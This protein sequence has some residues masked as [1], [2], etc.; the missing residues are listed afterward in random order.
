M[1]V[2][3]SAS[4]LEQDPDLK[5]QMGKAQFACFCGKSEQTFRALV[6]LTNPVFTYRDMP[7]GSER[8]DP[9]PGFTDA[10]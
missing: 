1:G 6:L 2:Y 9:I 8:V 5:L 10:C 3:A 7:A 4:K